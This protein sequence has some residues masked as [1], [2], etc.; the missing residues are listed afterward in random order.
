[1]KFNYEFQITIKCD[2]REH[3]GFRSDNEEPRKG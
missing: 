3:L 2:H 1:M